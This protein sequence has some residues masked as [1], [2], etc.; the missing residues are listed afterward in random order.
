VY[1]GTSLLADL[2]FQA[3]SEQ[4]KNFTGITPGDFELLI[5]L[6]VPKTVKRIQD[7]KQLC[8]LKRDWQ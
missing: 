3:F 7:S 6:I 4:Y 5:N 2:K 8:Q 1:S